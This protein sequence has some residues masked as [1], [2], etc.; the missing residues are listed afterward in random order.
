MN[1]RRIV[2]RDQRDKDGLRHLSARLNADGALLVEGQDLGPGV[3]RV[4]GDDI[5]EYE[6]VHTV[7]ASHVPALVTALGGPDGADVLE[8]LASGAAGHQ[9]GDL[10]RVLKDHRIPYDAWSRLGD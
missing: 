2:L 8:L 5:T 1:E 4:F 10:I 7:A 3:S 6:W 9:A